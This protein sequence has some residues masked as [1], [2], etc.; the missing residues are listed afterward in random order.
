MAKKKNTIEF[1]D[2][3]L[4]LD[5]KAKRKLARSIEKEKKEKQTQ[6]EASEK[7][8]EEPV[9]PTDI[10]SR[11]AM[12]CQ[13]MQWR[14]ALLLCREGLGKAKEEQNEDAE[15][16]LSMAV[17]KIDHSLR[18]QMATALIVASKDLLNKEYLLN[19]GK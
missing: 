13:N 6:Q 4:I 9:I 7:K 16:G 2:D 18:R 12:L 17:Q 5:R 11:V 10:M 8:S 1:D 15:F 19:V 14:E 3:D